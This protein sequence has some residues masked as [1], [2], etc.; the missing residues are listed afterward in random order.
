MP[1]FNV[2][3]VEVFEHAVGC[4][5]VSYLSWFFVRGAFGLGSNI[6]LVLLTTSILGLTHAVFH[7]RRTRDTRNN[8]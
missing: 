1:L 3:A 6:P 2:R 7:N 8:H 4:I 5:F